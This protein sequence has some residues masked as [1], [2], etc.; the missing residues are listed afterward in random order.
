MLGLTKLTLTFSNAMHTK[1][2]VPLWAS[3]WLL[4]S[5]VG[6]GAQELKTIYFISAISVMGGFGGIGVVWKTEPEATWKELISSALLSSLFSFVVAAILI[7]YLSM[8]SPGTIAGSSVLAGIG[9]DQLLQPSIKALGTRIGNI[10]GGS[11][12]TNKD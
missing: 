8:E 7:D 2:E 10:F 6:I 4:S 3:I 5:L 11:Q 1:L 12:R 9:T